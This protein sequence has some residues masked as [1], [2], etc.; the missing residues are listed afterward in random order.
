MNTTYVAWLNDARAMELGLVQTIESHLLLVKD[1]PTLKERLQKH[2]EETRQHAEIIGECIEQYGGKIAL[3]K[4]VMSTIAGGVGGAAAAL[5][6]DDLMKAMLSDAAAEA[7]EIASYTSLL[8]AARQLG[9]DFTVKACEGILADELAHQNW[10][11][12]QIPRLT[13]RFLAQD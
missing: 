9:D 13:D 8:E 2:L 10:I 11:L 1:E 4:G 5:T 12:E 7:L 3:F 6:G